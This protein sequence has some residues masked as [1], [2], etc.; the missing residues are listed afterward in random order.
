M[1]VVEEFSVASP[2]LERIKRRLGGGSNLSHRTARFIEEAIGKATRLARPKGVYTIREVFSIEDGKLCLAKGEG[3]SL[4]RQVTYGL[5]GSKRLAVFVLT[6]GDKL[7]KE[8]GRLLKEGRSSE[9]VCLDAAGS[10]IAEETRRTMASHIQAKE[11]S[12]NESLSLPYS[13][14]YCGF[15]MGQQKGI[16]AMVDSFRIKLS[17]TESCLMLPRKSISGLIGI[18]K[19][20]K[21]PPNPCLICKRECKERRI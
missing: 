15:G 8:T 19:F 12:S 7:E 4:S 21:R 6:I 18:G 14:G 11:T 9:A 5:Y 17:L 16:F 10:V 20:G 3:F 2:R 1:K 13:P